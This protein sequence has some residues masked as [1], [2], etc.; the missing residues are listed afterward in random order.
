[1]ASKWTKLGIFGLNLHHMAKAAYRCRTWN[2]P[3]YKKIKL[4]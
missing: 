3:L 1:M 4:L 2:R